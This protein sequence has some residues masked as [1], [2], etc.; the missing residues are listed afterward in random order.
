M[1]EKIQDEEAKYQSYEVRSKS[2]S[3]TLFFA[4]VICFLLFFF[5]ISR[6]NLARQ[7]WVSLLPTLGVVAFPLCFHPLTTSWIYKPW[8][9]RRRKSEQT[10]LD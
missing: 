10:Y 5:L 3:V 4:F 2:L 6:A 9:A 8:Q 1:A 7:S